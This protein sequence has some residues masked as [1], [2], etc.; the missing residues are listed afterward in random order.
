MKAYIFLVILIIIFNTNVYVQFHQQ[1]ILDLKNVRNDNSLE[2]N[3]FSKK[4]IDITVLPTYRITTLSKSIEKINNTVQNIDSY[5]ISPLTN[6]IYTLA[7]NILVK[8]IILPIFIL[9]LIIRLKP[10]IFRSP[11]LIVDNFINATGDTEID[12]VLSGLSQLYREKLIDSMDLVKSQVKVHVGEVDRRDNMPLPKHTPFKRPSPEDNVEHTLQSLINSLSEV[13]PPNIKPLISLVNILP[14]PRGIKVSSI[15]QCIRNN[16]KK[17]GIT[18][19]IAD[20]SKKQEPRIHT[21]WVLDEFMK[22]KVEDLSLHEQYE[23]L[24]KPA[25][26]WLALEIS[27]IIMLEARP[28]RYRF[29]GNKTIYEAYIF[30]FFGYMNLSF[31]IWGHIDFYKLAL[32]NF[33]KAIDLDEDWYQPYENLGDTYSLKG[34]EEGKEGDDMQCEA[35][36]Q[37][38]KALNKTKHIKNSTE[39]NMVESRIKISIA[40]ARLLTDKQDQINK[41]KK[42]IMN[43][44]ANHKY[45]EEEI[46]PSSLYNLACWFALAKSKYKNTEQD[47]IKKMAHLCLAYSLVRD[48]NKQLWNQ[49]DVDMDLNNV[50][51]IDN[52]KKT[53]RSLIENPQE[54]DSKIKDIPK[55]L[56]VDP[57]IIIENLS[58]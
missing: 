39:K 13:T 5:Y 44:V 21:I 58:D 36:I 57:K 38:K 11:E 54:I 55:I 19:K 16:P 1:K 51:P 46:N 20:F 49:I 12:K 17:I 15:L 33:N 42:E 35:I 9:L 30:N 37:Y 45:F 25:A 7:I 26:N 4:N 27:R 6:S 47:S 22:E 23:F 14:S 3:D 8:L 43:I 29:P 10:Y 28:W 56:R 31:Q 34:Q 18:L 41:A 2:I 40:L 32:D 48:R 53:I 24:L 50:R 52:F